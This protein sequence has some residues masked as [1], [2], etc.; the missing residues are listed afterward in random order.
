MLQDVLDV[1]TGTDIWDMFATAFVYLSWILD[2]W[3]LLIISPYRDVAD[4]ISPGPLLKA[5]ID[6]SPIQSTWIPP[7]VKFEVDDYN[8]KWISW[9]RWDLSHSREVLGTVPDW[10]AFYKKALG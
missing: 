7:N 10:L 1:G 2:L 3:A 4:M 5:S 9:N 6:L 8:K